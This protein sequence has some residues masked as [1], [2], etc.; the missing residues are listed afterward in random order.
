MEGGWRGMFSWPPFHWNTMETTCSGPG[1]FQ[2]QSVFFAPSSIVCCL[3]RWRHKDSILALHDVVAGSGFVSQSTWYPPVINHGWQGK[4]EV[5][6]GNHRTKG[7]IFQHATIFLQLAWRICGVTLEDSR[8]G[9]AKGSTGSFS[10]QKCSKPVLV[11]YYMGLYYPIYWGLSQSI[12]GNPIDQQL[13]LRLKRMLHRTIS[14]RLKK[15]TIHINRSININLV[16][17]PINF[18]QCCAVGFRLGVQQWEVHSAKALLEA[19]ARP[20]GIQST[21]PETHKKSQ[22]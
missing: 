12:I 6:M 11:E 3:H 16:G 9:S 20:E 15:C 21:P 19:C 14:R 5:S 17:T 4:M 22:S 1:S 13:C 2:Q 8:P 10:I 7:G 18:T